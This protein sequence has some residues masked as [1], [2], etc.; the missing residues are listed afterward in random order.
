MFSVCK[1]GTGQHGYYLEQ[2]QG[3]IT[4]AQAVS[5]GVED[6]YLSGPEAP[7]MW[8]GAGASALGLTGTSAS[9]RS[10]TCSRESIRVAASRSA[11]CSAIGGRGLI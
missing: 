7:G 5:S 6:Y 1:L 2:A 4:R 10:S 9:S 8:V 3:S 11:A